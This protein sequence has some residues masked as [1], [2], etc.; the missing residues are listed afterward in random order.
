M[1]G[2]A[3]CHARGVCALQLR[4]CPPYKGGELPIQ[5]SNSHAGRAPDFGSGAGGPSL[6]PPPKRGV[7]RAE[8]TRD[9]DY[10]QILPVFDSGETHGLWVR[11]TCTGCVSSTDAPL[12]YLSA[13]AFLGA[14]TMR[15][16]TPRTVA[17]GAARGRSYEV[18]PQVPHPVPVLRRPAE[19]APRLERDHGNIGKLLEHVKNI[20][21]L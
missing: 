1:V 6:F 14:R 17:P 20:I 9:L 21:H 16:L 10:S 5:L 12:R 4:P 15:G 11:R 7:W 13:F 19:N 18:R 2:R 8:M 3:L